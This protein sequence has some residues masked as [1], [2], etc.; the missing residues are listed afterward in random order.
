MDRYVYKTSVL[1]KSLFGV[2]NISKDASQFLLVFLSL[3]H[4]SLL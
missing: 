1:T 4:Q 3:M 2:F